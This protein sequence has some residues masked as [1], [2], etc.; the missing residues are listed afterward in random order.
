MRF[1]EA[2]R[3]WEKGRLTQE[4]AALLLGVCERTF[5]R[6]INRYEDEGLEG[7]IDKRIS[8]VSHRR[9]PVDEVIE[10]TD[11]Y[12]NRHLGWNTTHFYAWYRR[13]GGV[14]SY[15]WVK[16]RLQEGGG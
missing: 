1:E 13:N 14:R 16:S 5:R 12:R 11:T 7:L 2:Y 15:T 9:A 4:E 3:G 8:M 6:Q 10:V